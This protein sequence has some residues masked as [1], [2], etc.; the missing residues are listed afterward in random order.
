[1]P[2][3]W[4]FSRYECARHL[5]PSLAAFD[6]QHR[7]EDGLHEVLSLGLRHHFLLNRRR[8]RTL[9]VVFHG[10]ISAYGGTAKDYSL[11]YFNGMGMARQLKSDVLMFSDSTLQLMPRSVRVSWYAGTTDFDLPALLHRMLERIIAANEYEQVYFCGGS[12]GGFVSLRAAIAFPNAM[13]VVWN[14]QTDIASYRPAAIDKYAQFAFGHRRFDEIPRALRRAR[15]T[16]LVSMIR[17]GEAPRVLYLQNRSDEFH[18]ENHAAPFLGKLEVAVPRKLGL[19][20]ARPR[21]LYLLGD[22]GEGHVAPPSGS[23][24]RIL[25][26]AIAASGSMAELRREIPLVAP[27]LFG[28]GMAAA[29]PQE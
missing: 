24:G 21:V 14:P 29:A 10:A 3:E 12:G 20:Q 25:N 4:D 13:A 28:G 5:H 23:I 6:G 19:T 27:D 7:F 17:P 26:I 1:M 15:Q 11:P 8:S 16:D 2:D 22:W 18:V 9:V